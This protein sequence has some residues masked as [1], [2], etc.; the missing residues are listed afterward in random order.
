[1]EL[2]ADIYNYTVAAE[3]YTPI[4]TNCII[5]EQVKYG[6]HIRRWLSD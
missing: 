6:F 4:D 2:A 3:S 1:M 5:G